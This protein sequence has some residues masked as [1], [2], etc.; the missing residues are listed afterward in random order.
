VSCVFL[1]SSF[2]NFYLVRD[3]KP[4]NKQFFLSGK[5][6]QTFIGPEQ[7]FSKFSWLYWLT[8]FCAKNL[9]EMSCPISISSAFIHKIQ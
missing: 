4:P 6:E 5:R 1:I 8:S 3:I 9:F 7:I 2:F